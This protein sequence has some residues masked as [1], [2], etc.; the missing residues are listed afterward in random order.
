[1]GWKYREA[2]RPLKVSELNAKKAE[3]RKQRLESTLAGIS[4]QGRDALAKVSISHNT[5]ENLQ[6]LQSVLKDCY[7][8]IAREFVIMSGNIKCFVAFI[9][10]MVKKEEIN[11]NVLKPLMAGSRAFA[12]EEQPIMDALAGYL[13]NSAVYVA[14]QDFWQKFS[15]FLA[16]TRHFY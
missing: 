2:K 12:P 6:N 1:M 10:G 15:R 8:F 13:K 16:K 11:D 9:D 4:R 7:D 14:A 5:G 3:R